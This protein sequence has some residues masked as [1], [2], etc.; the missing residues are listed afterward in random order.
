MNKNISI[1]VLAALVLVA[2]FLAFKA[3]SVIS[4]PSEIKFD[5]SA[6]G[7]TK[8]PVVNV[9][10]PIVNVAAPNVSVNVP[11]QQAQTQSLGSITSPD[12]AQ[13]YFSV[14]G[15]REW[16]E[17]K[18]LM[19]NSSTT[20]SFKLPSA[21]TTQFVAANAVI[22]SSSTGGIFEIGYNPLSAFS[23]S[24]LITQ[25]TVAVSATDAVLSTSSFSFG[26]PALTPPNTLQPGGYI[27]FKYQGTGSISGFC[28]YKVR[29]L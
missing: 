5:A 10:A 14:G 20:C 15:V 17:R 28:E 21:S 11:Q 26:L 12:V 25:K 3:P 4:V 23:T 29:E 7:S 24:T 6:L 13:T 27:N 18:A 19:S 16:S 2:G 8:A 1:G 9:P 22:A